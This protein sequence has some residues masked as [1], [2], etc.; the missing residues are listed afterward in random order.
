MDK[1]NDGKISLSEW[2]SG[3]EAIAVFCGEKAF[4]TALLK[5]SRQA[6]STQLRDMILTEQN[7]KKAMA[8]PFEAPDGSA[9]VPFSKK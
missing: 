6:K 9:K 7:R 4:L 5:W 8:E 2:L 1:D 3:T